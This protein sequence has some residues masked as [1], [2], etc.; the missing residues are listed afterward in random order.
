MNQDAVPNQP[1]DEEDESALPPLQAMAAAD[2]PGGAA[3]DSSAFSQAFLPAKGFEGAKPGYVFK[4]GGRGLG[5]YRDG[6]AEPMKPAT[7]RAEGAK[8]KVAEVEDLEK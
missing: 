1:L 8:T 5:Y 6:A 7:A 3:E 2:A 4:K